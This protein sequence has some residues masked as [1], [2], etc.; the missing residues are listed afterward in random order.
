M[1]KISLIVLIMGLFIIVPVAQAHR[2]K[3]D[4]QS[5]H[6]CWTNCAQWG[7]TEGFYHCHQQV[8]GKTDFTTYTVGQEKSGGASVT[9]DGFS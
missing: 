6:H 9:N 7:M 5:C 4:S 1:R 8:N 3:L 2:G